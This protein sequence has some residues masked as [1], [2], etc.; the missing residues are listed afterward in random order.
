[1]GV[2]D[3]DGSQVQRVGIKPD[4][5]VE[6]TLDSIKQNRDVILEAGIGH[7]QTKDPNQLVQ[8]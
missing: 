1:M 6:E 7:F 4:L 8:Q 5:F 2:Q 3:R